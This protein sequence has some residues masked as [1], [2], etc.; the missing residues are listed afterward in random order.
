M[1]QP[2]L[3]IY[4][5]M[6]ELGGHLSAGDVSS[7][8]EAR[9]RGLPR[10]TIYNVLA[11]L[12]RAGLV[13]TADAGPGR[14]LYEAAEEWHHHFVCRSCQ[15]VVDVPCLEG[16]KPCLEPPAGVP[17]VVDEAQVIFRGVCFDCAPSQE[18]PDSTEQER[19]GR[20]QVPGPWR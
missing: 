6:R 13:M 3:V 17:G 4:Q 2:R 19:D 20:E 1:T 18:T 7:Q 12:Q 10:M 11:D 9:D 8:L 16:R 15:R 5:L 14:T